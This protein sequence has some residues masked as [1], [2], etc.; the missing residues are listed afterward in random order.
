M[1]TAP[2]NVTSIIGSSQTLTQGQ[3]HELRVGA[4][5][6][7][8]WKLQNSCHVAFVVGALTVSRHHVAAL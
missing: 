4:F 1:N 6:W 2:R 5:Q 8:A 3:F 7:Y